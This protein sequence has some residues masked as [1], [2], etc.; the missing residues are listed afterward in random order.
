ML[1]REVFGLATLIVITAAVSAAIVRGDATA[2]LIEA[3]GGTFNNLVK[4]A[5]LSGG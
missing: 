1:V 3:A 5:T 2:R 4:T